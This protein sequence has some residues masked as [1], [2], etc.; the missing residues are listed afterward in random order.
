MALE[1]QVR[2]EIG[3]KLNNLA[4]RL[5]EGRTNNLRDELE[6]TLDILN[7]F[8][9]ISSTDISHVVELTAS[10]L[11]ELQV[12]ASVILDDQSRCWSL[13]SIDRTQGERGAPQYVIPSEMIESL[14]EN[15]FNVPQISRLLGVSDKTVRRRMTEYGLS[16][17][18]TYSNLTDEELENEISSIIHEFPYVGYKTLSSILCSKGHRLQQMRVRSAVRRVDPEGTLVRR[19][20]AASH[21]LQRRKY[22]VRAPLALW[23]LDGNHKLITPGFSSRLERGPG[24]Q[25]SLGTSLTWW[26]VF[27]PTGKS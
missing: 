9:S 21:R 18:S 6:R 4:R 10:A 16:V 23:H 3:E 12:N 25:F 22:S 19:L 26:A 8:A 11:N 14:L 20:F 2:E 7:Q 1:Q 13:C 5:T 17:T 27:V 24:A 15:H